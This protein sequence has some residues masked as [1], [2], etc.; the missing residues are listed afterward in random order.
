MDDAFH[1]NA[2][3]ALPGSQLHHQL[4]SLPHLSSQRFPD[5]HGESQTT[6]P[7]I[8]GLPSSTSLHHFSSINNH[9]GSTSQNSIASHASHA[10]TT[11]PPSHS[12]AYQQMASQ[13][14]LRT[15]QPP[16]PAYSQAGSSYSVSQA[17]MPSPATAYTNS[18]SFSSMPMTAAM[19]NIRP[20]PQ[21]GMAYP[22]SYGQA[23]LLSQPHALPPPDPEPTHVV[24]QQGRRGVLPSAP[25]RAVPGP[26]K[27]LIPQKDAD[28][29]FPC[30]HCTKTYLHA[31]H[32]KRHLLRR[33]FS[34]SLLVHNITDSERHRRSTLH[35]QA[36]QG[37]VLTKRYPQAPLSEVFH[38]AGCYRRHGPSRRVQSAPQPE[39]SVDWKHG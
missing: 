1:S 2:Y 6:L 10:P 13:P 14:P 33:R 29:K 15:L 24:G 5:H 31:K 12:Y 39:P 23:P 18:Q 32:L 3:S 28:G 34:A 19:H 38:K 36:L 21:N 35:V 11:L 16:L 25:G 7:P 8:S 17:T 37:H 4:T 26:G 9:G 30:P 22:M 27:S 20:R